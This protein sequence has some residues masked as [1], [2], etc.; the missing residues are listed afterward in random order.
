MSSPLG[1]GHHLLGRKWSNF[2]VIIE[3]DKGLLKSIKITGLLA[4]E[5]ANVCSVRGP[6]L[7]PFGMMEGVVTSAILGSIADQVMA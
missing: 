5:R 3:L 6:T 7:R 4:V 1:W 2:P